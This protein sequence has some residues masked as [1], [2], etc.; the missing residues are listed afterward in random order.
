MT[1]ASHPLVTGAWVSK[2]SDMAKVLW[3]V[4]EIVDCSTGVIERLV[5]THPSV[6]SGGEVGVADS[7]DASG[8]SFAWERSPALDVDR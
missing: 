1:S 5:L 7:R 2:N 8:V 6:L 4:W 3:K